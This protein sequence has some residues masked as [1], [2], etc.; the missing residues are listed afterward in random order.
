MFTRIYPVPPPIYIYIYIML[1]LHA[2]TPTRVPHFV[3]Y[4]HRIRPPPPPPLYTSSSLEVRIIY[5]CRY[6]HVLHGRPV[7]N[8]FIITL[9][10]TGE[11]HRTAFLIISLWS[12]VIHDAMIFGDY[13]WT[14]LVAWLCVYRSWETRERPSSHSAG[15]RNIDVVAVKY[16]R[17]I[18]E[19]VW[20]IR[21]FSWKPEN[22]DA[23]RVRFQLVIRRQS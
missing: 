20:E 10:L 7:E 11:H 8:H 23:V 15:H 19:D 4:V 2:H 3:H 18:D 22:V 17:I 9:L 13:R 21:R 1:L 12:D 6:T 5:Y 14:C 16:T